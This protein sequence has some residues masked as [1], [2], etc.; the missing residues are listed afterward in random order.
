MEKFPVLGGLMSKI[1]ARKLRDTVIVVG[2][3]ILLVLFVY[4][5]R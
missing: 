4:Y 1:R 2:I 3:M 5:I